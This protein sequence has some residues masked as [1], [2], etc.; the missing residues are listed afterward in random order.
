MKPQGERTDSCPRSHSRLRGLWVI[1]PRGPA[2]DVLSFWQLSCWRVLLL[3]GL[4]FA[5]TVQGRNNGPL[6]LDL[7]TEPQHRQQPAHGTWTHW[8]SWSA[9]SSTCGDGVSFRIRRCIRLPGEEPCRAEARQYRVC[10]RKACPAGIV[11]FRAMQC[12]LYNSRPIL[13][14]QAQYQWVPFHGAANLCD[15]NCLAMGHNFYY[16]FGRVLD[17]TPCSPASPELCI[18]GRC[19]RAGCDGVLG[20][21]AQADACGVCGGKNESCVFIQEAFRVAVPASG[22]FG[23]R[24][25]TQIPVGARQIRVID[26]SRNYLALMEANQHYVLNGEWAVDQPG[27]FEAAGTQWHYTRT[28]NGHETLEA[29][30]S[31]S[32][33]LFVMVLFQDE[34]ISIDY[35]YWRPRKQILHRAQGEAHA[36]RQP[37]AKEVEAQHPG[38]PADFP[39]ATAATHRFTKAQE[40]AKEASQVTPAPLRTPS[41]PGP[42]GKCDPP[43]G[44]SQRLH[45]YCNSDFV[46]RARILSKRYVG[47]ETR[48]DVQVQQT[49]RNRFPLRSREYLWVPNT[50]DCPHLLERREYL[51]MARNH[52]N[53]EQTL[54]RLLLQSGGYARPWSPREDLLLRDAAPRCQPSPPA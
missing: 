1:Q 8:G 19:L 14:G 48:Y 54:N 49:Y 29:A 52:V 44:K 35:Q 6:E 39:E 16:S 34:N 41:A 22:F 46:F 31:T 27:V 2:S 37:Q 53:F 42:C 23:Y 38:E 40:V 17:G 20:S 25:V 30:G 28:A 24:N 47:S 10:E 4:V 15:L 43:R 36:L 21:E 7:E 32:G 12:T 26:N 9:C 45:H 5:C 51:L 33:D 50:C 13:G 11:P 18:S 3:I